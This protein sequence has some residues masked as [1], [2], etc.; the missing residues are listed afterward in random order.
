M[1]ALLRRSSLYGG[2]SLLRASYTLLWL[3][4]LLLHYD[5]PSQYSGHYTHYCSQSNRLGALQPTRLPRSCW[6]PP[7]GTTSTTY[8]HVLTPHCSRV[9]SHPVHHSALL[10]DFAFAVKL[11][12]SMTKADVS[13]LQI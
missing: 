12:A 4:S 10:R 5:M 13:N 2:R 8:S 9:I 11:V 6:H 1:N 7:T 3:I